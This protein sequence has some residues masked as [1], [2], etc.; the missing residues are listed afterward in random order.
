[1]THLS[2]KSSLTNLGYKELLFLSFLEAR[3][4]LLYY[5]GNHSSAS[6]EASLLLVL[7][8]TL[9]IAQ[10]ESHIDHV[11]RLGEPLVPV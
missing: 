4:Q 5:M 2:R 8:K 3:M 7:V 9:G 11:L 1:M 6:T 10:M